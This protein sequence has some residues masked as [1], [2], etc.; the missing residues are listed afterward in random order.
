MENSVKI[1][2]KKIYNLD[3]QEIYFSP[4]RVNIIGGHTDYNGGNVL[5]FCIDMG[6]YAAVSIRSDSNVYVYSENI[7][8]KGIISFDLTNLDYDF[9]R[10]FAN[11]ISGA[12]KVLIDLGLKLDKGINLALISNLPTGGGLSSS[13]ALLVLILTILNN[14]FNLNLS[15]TDIAL[16]AK[17]VEN[18]YIGVNCGI[19]DQFI[20]ANGKKNHALYLNTVNLEY[21]EIKV[22]LDD[23]QFVL[24]NSNI[25]RKLTESKYNERQIESKKLLHLLQEHISINNVC[26][27]SIKDY[28]ELKDYI[29]DETLKKRFEHLVFENHR[30]SQAKEALKNNDFIALGKLLDEAHDSI[31]NLYEVSSKVL[32]ELVA[33]AKEAGS[34]GSKMIGG[35]FGGSTLNIV[36]TAE[37]KAFQTEF[38]KLYRIKYKKEPVMQ[39]VRIMDG[40]KKIS[41]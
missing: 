5:P 4:G 20:I 17:R 24:V 29:L 8:N 36:K 6:I 23:Y 33:L 40:V 12:F 15:K 28:H 13:A 32:D 9:K 27:C 25:T 39:V 16:L 1:L 7:K 10:D 35:G 11:Y 14:N 2:F 18:D 22:S 31:K 26:D 34:L 38:T 3:Y 37:L 30:V 19:M 41:D 21:E